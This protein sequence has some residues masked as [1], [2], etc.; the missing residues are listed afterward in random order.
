[1][2]V[3]VEAVVSR[4]ARINMRIESLRGLIREHVPNMML[5][6]RCRPNE[7]RKHLILEK[8]Y[9]RLIFQDLWIYPSAFIV[10]L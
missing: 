3:S 9:A 5:R 7:I 2:K 4:P 10:Q 1:M 6:L 8:G